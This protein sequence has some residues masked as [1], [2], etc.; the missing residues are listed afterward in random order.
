MAEDSGVEQA[1]SAVD[2]LVPVADEVENRV[3]VKESPVMH[4][5]GPVYL[6]FALGLLPWIAYLAWHLPARQL[7][8]N[9]DVAWAGFDTM[10]CLGLGATAYFAM[11]RSRYLAIAAGSAGA[12]LVVDAWFDVLTSPS[13][14]ERVVA[15]VLA[16]LVEVPLAVL[17]FWIGMHSQQIAEQR[18]RFLLRRRRAA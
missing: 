2:D 9:Y 14:G 8:P 5:V 18:I 15:V 3:P 13:G 12:M 16:M 17:C 10:L 11:R 1:L 7:S 4:W 6:L